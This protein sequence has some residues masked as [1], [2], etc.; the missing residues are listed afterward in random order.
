MHYTFQILCVEKRKKT[1]IKKKTK[2]KENLFFAIKY[3]DYFVL[4]CD[5]RS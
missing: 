4:F 1:C 5:I 3:Y 2:M